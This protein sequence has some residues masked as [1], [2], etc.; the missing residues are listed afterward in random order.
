MT[1]DIR[2][3][4]R[5]VEPKEKPD[6]KYPD[7]RPVN[8]TTNVLQKSCTYNAHY[9]APRCGYYSVLCNDCGFTA[10]VTVA[11]RADDPRTITIPCKVKPQ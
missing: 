6:P 1:I 11:G 7:G 10:L 8:L 2:F 9:P 5:G 4:D 3:I